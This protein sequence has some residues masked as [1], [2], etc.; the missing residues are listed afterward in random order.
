MIGLPSMPATLSTSFTPSLT[1]DHFKCFHQVFDARSATLKE[2]G[3]LQ[4]F[5]SPDQKELFVNWHKGTAQILD[6]TGTVRTMLQAS[7]SSYTEYTDPRDLVHSEITSGPLQTLAKVALQ[8]ADNKDDRFM[9]SDGWPLPETLTLDGD[10]LRTDRTVIARQLGCH[11]G[12]I[13]R[14][15]MRP[16]LQQLP[17][18]IDSGHAHVLD[19]KQRTLQPLRDWLSWAGDA[20]ALKT[21]GLQVSEAC[22][23]LMMGEV[24]IDTGLLARMGM[25]NGVAGLD[26]PGAYRGLRFEPGKL[27]ALLRRG[28]PDECITAIRLLKQMMRSGVPAGDILRP[29]SGSAR[30]APP[31]ALT[32]QL[33]RLA[34]GVDDDLRVSTEIWRAI[35]GRPS[36]SPDLPLGLI[37]KGSKGL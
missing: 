36:E 18:D 5:L 6:G 26:A 28:Q 15:E 32:A 35:C 19:T 3:T 10:V 34:L 17:K 16:A 2:L 7:P 4:H 37:G 11:E 20:P 13:V 33:E 29:I 14:W 27:E 21:S 9:A 22:K 31:V 24:E 23:R 8:L 1:A 25:R 30:A 12:D